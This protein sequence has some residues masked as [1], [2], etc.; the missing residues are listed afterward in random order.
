MFDVIALMKVD[1]GGY[2]A[3]IRFESW[4]S[5]S[6]RLCSIEHFF[7]SAGHVGPNPGLTRFASIIFMPHTGV[8]L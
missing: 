3:V 7:G 6:P 1:V 8:E 2:L 5:N 4:P